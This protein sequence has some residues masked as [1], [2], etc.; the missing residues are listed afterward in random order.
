[1]SEIPF[2]LAVSHF[3]RDAQTADRLSA[4]GDQ[5]SQIMAGL[6]RDR[7][8]EQIRFWR[9]DKSFEVVREGATVEHTAALEQYLPAGYRLIPHK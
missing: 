3:I 9:N 2:V 4:Q 6:T 8:R 7:L 5:L 1:M